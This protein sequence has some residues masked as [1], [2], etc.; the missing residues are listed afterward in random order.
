MASRHSCGYLQ[1]AGLPEL[2]ARDP[3]DYVRIAAELAGD[4]PR[5]AALR[6][7]MRQ[8]LL[9]S[10]LCD[11]DGFVRDFRAALAKIH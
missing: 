3:D 10:P 9:D 6:T 7:G 11:V 1:N 8:R 4:L 5:L 2:I